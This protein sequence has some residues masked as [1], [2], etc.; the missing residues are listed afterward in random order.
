MPSKPSQNMPKYVIWM[1]MAMIQ[2][3]TLP[4]RSLNMRPETFGNQ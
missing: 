2:K 1:P 4:M 3:A